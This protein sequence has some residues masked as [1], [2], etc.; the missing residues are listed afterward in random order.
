MCS[1]ARCSAVLVLLLVALGGNKDHVCQGRIIMADNLMDFLLTSTA[2]DA[3]ADQP[4]KKVD[5]VKVKESE[6]EPSKESIGMTCH[7]K[8][9]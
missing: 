1:V 7:K 9:P 4:E 2:Q 5:D 3:T 8:E 6:E